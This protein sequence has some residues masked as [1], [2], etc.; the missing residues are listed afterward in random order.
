MNALPVE[1]PPDSGGYL[2][3][4]RGV[5]ADAHLRC[6]AVRLSVFRQGTLD[7]NRAAERLLR[8]LEPDEKAVS[9]CDD[10]FSMMRDKQGS[11]GLVVPPHQRFPRFVAEH[12]NQIG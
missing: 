3:C 6:K 7:G 5:H 11:Q 9:R 10:L 12:L 1:I 4:I 2:G 8:A